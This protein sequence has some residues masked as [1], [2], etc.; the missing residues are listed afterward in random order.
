MSISSMKVDSAAFNE[1]AL[2]IGHS[3]TLYG[4]SNQLI[5]QFGILLYRSEGQVVQR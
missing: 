2:D 3:A 1:F 4:L 5:S